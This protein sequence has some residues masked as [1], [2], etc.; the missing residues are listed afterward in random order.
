M[1]LCLKNLSQWIKSFGHPQVLKT[2]RINF[3]G[4]Q[5][6]PFSERI[7]ATAASSTNSGFYHQTYTIHW[8][9]VRCCLHDKMFNSSTNELK[10]S[11]ELLSMAW[12]NWARLMRWLFLQPM[13]L[14]MKVSSSLAASSPPNGNWFDPP[15]IL[16]TKKRPPTCK[17]V[18]PNKQGSLPCIVS[19]S[20]THLFP[21]CQTTCNLLNVVLS[22]KMQNHICT[23][24]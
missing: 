23:P 4:P 18:L 11:A 13:V 6:T 8:E 9:V 14:M 20:V 5:L 3:H 7:L 19:A 1:P 17:S 10:S 16:R 21:S 12:D 24:T 22:L 15:E 2:S